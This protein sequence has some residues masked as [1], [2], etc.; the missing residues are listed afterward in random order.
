ML[1]AMV[2][3]HAGANVTVSEI[4]THR[5]A[6]AKDLGIDTINPVEVDAV[7]TLMNSTGGKG[8]DVVFEVS[9]TQPG[10]DLMTCL[11]Y[12]SPSPRDKRQSRMPS[13]A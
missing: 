8:V 1:I 6:M 2:A 7:E 11:L 12:T 13:S 5:I 10:V 3:K 9:G 4:N